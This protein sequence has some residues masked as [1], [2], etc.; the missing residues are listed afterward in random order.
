MPGQLPR[1]AAFQAPRPPR[2][3]P[4]E[5]GEAAWLLLGTPWG[6]APHAQA[7][8]PLP[9]PRAPWVPRRPA[10]PPALGPPRD[11]ADSG[12]DSPPQRAPGCLGRARGGDRGE[13]EEEDAAAE[14]EDL[15]A[16]ALADADARF[17]DLGGL[18]VHY[19]E[20]LPPVRPHVVPCTN[21]GGQSPHALPCIKGGGQALTLCHASRGV[22]KPSRS[23]MHQGGGA[24]PH[25]LPCI[26]GG[27]QSP[28]ALP[29]I[30]GGGQALVTS[31]LLFQHSLRTCPLPV[32]LL[33]NQISTACSIV[34][35]AYP[36]GGTKDFV[37]LLV[38]YRS[39][40][41]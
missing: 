36:S 2:R 21:G 22:G 13:K 41:T 19:K 40:C 16:A 28:H 31:R 3:Y 11:S 33:L 12:L 5:R 32:K 24:S 20:A 1:A 17:A 9:A 15:P 29:C 4:W 8:L 34:I 18:A 7:T 26:K 39:W 6:A 30:K 10:L 27:G 38:T 14:D 25:A 37:R 35:N 23:A